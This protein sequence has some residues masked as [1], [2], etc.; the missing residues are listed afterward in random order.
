MGDNRAYHRTS[1]D[2]AHLPLTWRGG[3][4][5]QQHQPRGGVRLQVLLAHETLGARQSKRLQTKQHR[6]ERKLSYNNRNRIS[7]KAKTAKVYGGR[8]GG[9]ASSRVVTTKK[10]V[11]VHA[12]EMLNWCVRK[13]STVC[14]G[15]QSKPKANTPHGN[16]THEDSFGYES[17]ATNIVVLHRAAA[18]GSG[19]V[20]QC[21]EITP[22]HR[23]GVGHD[24]RG[25]EAALVYRRGDA[26][27]EGSEGERVCRRAPSS[28]ESHGANRA[29]SQRQEGGGV[30]PPAL[31]ERSTTSNQR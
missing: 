18:N 23:H 11:A 14:G 4:G 9:H 1:T 28:C 5:V 6:A 12:P 30:L 17:A 8:R 7:P 3:E 13:P 19:R 27:L 16:G 29:P 31:K 21:T 15:I 2:L 26:G 22:N 25:C 24:D 20:R 10:I